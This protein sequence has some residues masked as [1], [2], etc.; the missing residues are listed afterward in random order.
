MFR[1]RIWSVV[2]AGI[3]C[4]IVSWSGPARSQ[5]DPSAEKT[6]IAETIPGDPNTE[7]AITTKDLNIPVE[8]LRLMV[9]PL[10]LEELEVEAAAWLLILKEKVQEISEVEIAIRR[11]NLAIA[12]QE[13]A[14]S[15]LEAAQQ[16][17]AEAEEAQAQAAPDS[18]EYHEATKKIESAKENIKNA[19]S[20]LEEAQETQQGLQEDDALNAA[21][22]KA[23]ETA[24]LEKAR[25]VLEQAKRDREEVYWPGTV[26]YEELVGKIDTLDTAI[27]ELEK[28]KEDLRGA[29]PNSPEAEEAT[30]QFDAALEKVKKAREAISGASEPQSDRGGQN[31]A[32]DR[33]A[34][35]LENTEID[36]D[37]QTLVAGP[38]GIEEDANLQNQQ[39]ELED[40]AEQ[41][42]QSAEEE[43]EQKNQ[44]VVTVT[45]LI[46]ERTAIVD[47]FKVILQ[48][49]ESKGGD[50][51]SY[52]QF[53]SA[54]GVVEIDVQDT[55][56]LALRA[57][58]WLKS[59]EGGM[60]WAGNIGKFTGIMVASIVVAQGL[61]ILLNRTL[62]LFPGISHL[63][64]EFVVMLVKR[65][66]IV[67]GVLLALTA[68]EVSLGPILA[69]V[70]GVSF[71][72]AFALQSNLGNFASGLML[73][74]YKPFD[75]G[76]EI[77]M[78]GIW[79]Y[80][81]SITLANTRLQGFDRQMINIPNNTVWSS[82]ITNLTRS[83]TRKATLCIRI[84]FHQSIVQSER[85]LVD[86]A[87][88]HPLVLDDPP[89]GTFPW[90]YDEYFI[91]I[92][93][94]FT[95]KTDDF[96]SAWPDIIR[97]IQIRF[98]EEGLSVALP[99][100][101]IRVDSKSNGNGASAGKPAFHMEHPV[102]PRISAEGRPP[103]VEAF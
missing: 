102:D 54:I 41:L 46:N 44:L 78:N 67:V 48:E 55:E 42:K 49:L 53:I 28:A 94:G 65:G 73:M 6:F 66:G 13:E 75:V 38:T 22:A 11:Q 81:D 61:G 24:E 16:S 25:E 8:E 62:M 64:R 91:A 72:L 99:E 19:Q 92:Y 2:V 93:F 35:S 23:E 98:E 70:G 9:K 43:S 57:V 59:D 29:E 32:T 31:D 89:P 69:L 26:A 56:G 17:L 51:T 37:G 40:S 47:R 12:K 1:Y 87:K 76:D 60:R 80:V 3:A 50:P 33:V 63:L 20:A 103:S 45:E 96:W 71:V 101:N 83:E 30:R 90:E 88:S 86:L 18:L 34:A 52:S 36:S 27:R 100:Q 39:E 4:T 10:T 58:S 82:T 97:H 68:L 84:P 77:Q 7:S 15:E 74:V 85:I 79:G 5:E 21:L 14:A 95:T